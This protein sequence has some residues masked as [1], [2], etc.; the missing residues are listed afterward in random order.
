M[1]NNKKVVADEQNIYGDNIVDMQKKLK[2]E[3]TL[4]ELQ[5][6]ALQDKAEINELKSH[7]TEVLS[8]PDDFFKND[9]IKN[10]IKEIYDFSDYVETIESTKKTRTKTVLKSETDDVEKT[11][12]NLEAEKESAKKEINLDKFVDSKTDL[13]SLKKTESSPYP[14]GVSINADDYDKIA[15]DEVVYPEE[16]SEDNFEEFLDDDEYNEE[17]N[18]DYYEDNNYNE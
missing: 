6:K 9:N 16:E 10:L 7:L 1:S 15:D 2:D 4:I 3:K 8:R 11:N 17:Q 13:E 14:D 12:E 18:Y 5:I